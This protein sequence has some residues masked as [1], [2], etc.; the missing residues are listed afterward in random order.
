MGSVTKHAAKT[1]SRTPDVD[2]LL[3]QIGGG[4]SGRAARTFIGRLKRKGKSMEE[5]AEA[6]G[7]RI[8]RWKTI[9]EVHKRK[10]MGEPYAS[11]AEDLPV[12]VTMTQKYGKMAPENA[13][14]LQSYAQ[15]KDVRFDVLNGADRARILGSYFAMGVQHNPLK[16]KRTF[17]HEEGAQ[18]LAKSLQQATNAKPKI[19]EYALKGKKRFEVDC[20]SVELMRDIGEATADKTRLPWEYLASDEERRAFLSGYLDAKVPDSPLRLKGVRPAIQLGS[21]IS[22]EGLQRDLQ[23]LFATQGIYSS[24]NKVKDGF[25]IDIN[26]ERDI[27]RILD[28]NLV[29][30]MA[31]RDDAAFHQQA[32][33]RGSGTFD[34]EEY[35]WVK[36]YIRKNKI[37]EPGKQAG[38]ITQALNRHLIEEEGRSSNPDLTTSQLEETV[39]DM[40]ENDPD[41]LKRG[42]AQIHTWV[43]AKNPLKPFRVK[44]R[45]RL[46]KAMKKR[47]DPRTY[48]LLYRGLGFDRETTVNAAS[49]HRNKPWDWYV[50]R[51][52]DTYP[53]VMGWLAKEKIP[54]FKIEKLL[55]ELGRS[56]GPTPVNEAQSLIRELLLLSNGGDAAKSLLQEHVNHRA[57]KPPS[58]AQPTE[59]LYSWARTQV[60]ARC[61]GDSESDATIQ[62]FLDKNFFPG[63]TTERQFDAVK[64]KF[65]DIADSIT[66]AKAKQP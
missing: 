21:S 22:D 7:E 47:P 48:A 3:K 26:G 2:G 59:R 57:K 15:A 50:D 44:L 56:K 29:S 35:D 25:R 43:R 30:S 4:S 32:M 65:Q 18:K 40:I 60:L 28:L 37:R 45:D 55:T 46:E 54:S 12:G 17:R 61:M 38:R 34:V 19:R 53:A 62:S 63:S 51:S 1:D 9:V 5:I 64:Q 13:F 20:Q 24:L 41:I 6:L 10:E 23:A 42:Y 27:R 39:E 14:R 52:I 49:I 58:N 36:A 8:A 11:I 33:P 31:F 66:A 16:L